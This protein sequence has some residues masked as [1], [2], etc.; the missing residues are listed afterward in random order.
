MSDCS[1]FVNKEED[2][3]IGVKNVTGGSL[4]LK[5]NLF[6]FHYPYGYSTRLY[7]I[8]EEPKN[9]FAFDIITE[10]ETK[11]INVYRDVPFKDRAKGIIDLSN[12]NG[13]YILEISNLTFDDKR[14]IILMTFES[15]LG[16][17]NAVRESITFNVEGKLFNLFK[18]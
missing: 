7:Y 18:H 9:L 4:T 1:F 8:N 12:G 5:W 2:N 13:T 3:V 10:T 16:L 17:D 14:V 11:I 6:N 15:G